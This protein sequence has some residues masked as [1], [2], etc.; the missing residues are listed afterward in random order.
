MMESLSQRTT[1]TEKVLM[2]LPMFQMSLKPKLWQVSLINLMILKRTNTLLMS[3]SL[4]VRDTQDS[5]I[6]LKKLE[7]DK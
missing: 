2:A 5:M 3:E 4:L 6:G 1:V 7:L